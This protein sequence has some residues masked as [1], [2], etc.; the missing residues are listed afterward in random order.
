[1]S[2]DTL[3]QEEEAAV[4][5]MVGIEQLTLSPSR[6]VGY[7]PRPNATELRRIAQ[8]GVLEPVA[9]R[10]LGMQAFEILS[11]PTTWVAAGQAGLRELQVIVYEDLSEEEVAAIVADHYRSVAANPLDEAR[12]FAAQLEALG[13]VTR[14]GA[15]TRLSHRLGVPR[16]RLSHA[17]RLLD[18]PLAIQDRIE[19]GELTA[20]HARPLVSIVGRRQQIQLADKIVAGRLSVRQ[21][22]ALAREHRAESTGRR[23]KP[24]TVAV[25]ADVLRLQQRVSEVAGCPFDLRGNEA[26]FNFFGDYEILDGLLER[27]GY[28]HE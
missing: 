26:V 7:V 13:D 11:R 5:K 15:V 21:A 10:P 27:L 22:E 16:P 17:L 6:P 14:R 8:H 9:V 12:E 3:I 23:A 24:A 20:G 19:R 18:L 4:L 2:R 25:N 1:V 28:C